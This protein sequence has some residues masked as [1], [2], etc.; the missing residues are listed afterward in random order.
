ML[1][2]GLRRLGQSVPTL[3]AVSVLTF[4][5]VRLIPGDPAVLIA[6]EEATPETLRGIREQLALDRPLAEQYLVYAGRLLQGDLGTSIR[7]K[8]PV[9]G[10][11]AARIPATVELALAALLVLVVVG[12]LLGVAAAVWRDRWPDHLV[13]VLSL[14]GVSTPTFWLGAVLILLFAIRFRLFPVSGRGA[15]VYLV[16]PAVTAS[17]DGVAL[18]ARLVRASLLD[19]LAEDYVRTG[20]AKGLGEGPVVWRHALRNALI[21][22]VTVL[23]LELGRLLGGVVVVE[24][25]FGWPGFGRL[26]VTAIQTRDYPLVQSAILVFGAAVILLNLAIDL[27]LG[28]LDPRVRYR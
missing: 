19:V 9:A 26:L 1:R 3:V 14:V 12:T 10:E 28:L 13:R 15:L 20:R 24:S 22:V 11:L 7:S 6:G 16:L 23:G 2:Y 5:M 18:V 4:A 17:M 8:Q 21:P 25:V 27:S